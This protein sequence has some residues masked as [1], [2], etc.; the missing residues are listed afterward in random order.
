MEPVPV[1]LWIILIAV[2]PM[3]AAGLLLRQ[4]VIGAGLPE[5]RGRL[6]WALIIGAVLLAVLVGI[7]FWR[8]AAAGG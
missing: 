5:W 6:A 1:L 2:V 7:F 4:G 8:L 3:A